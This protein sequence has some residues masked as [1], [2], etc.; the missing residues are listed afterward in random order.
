MWSIALLTCQQ[1]IPGPGVARGTCRDFSMGANPVPPA[2]GTCFPSFTSHTQR[3]QCKILLISE[4][5]TWKTFSVLEK[6]HNGW[7]NSWFLGG[8]EASCSR[9]SSD[10]LLVVLGLETRPRHQGQAEQNRIND[11]KFLE[12][13]DALAPASFIKYLWGAA[14]GLAWR[15]RSITEGAVWVWDPHSADPPPS[16][17]PQKFWEVFLE[18]LPS[19]HTDKSSSGAGE[20][21]DGLRYPRNKSWAEKKEKQIYLATLPVNLQTQPSLGAVAVPNKQSRAISNT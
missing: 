18:P 12:C 10:S 15:Q 5:S 16:V 21:R 17:T 19:L 9:W 13:W 7:R 1:P 11:R 3:N 8:S 6:R 4:P 14:P 2:P 20:L